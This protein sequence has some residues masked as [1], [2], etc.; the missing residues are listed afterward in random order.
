MRIFT[1]VSSIVV[2]SLVTLSLT[3]CKKSSVDNNSD[4]ESIVMAN[5]DQKAII[6]KDDATEVENF[7]SIIKDAKFEFE[8]SE[9]GDIF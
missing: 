9:E 2:L 6:L 3:A 5:E 4:T 8:I 1:S 7:A